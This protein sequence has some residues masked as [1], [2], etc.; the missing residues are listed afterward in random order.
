MEEQIHGHDSMCSMSVLENELKIMDSFIAK[1]KGEEQSFYKS[2]KE[3]IEF[4][5]DMLE[6]NIQNG[7]ITVD[8]YKANIM[9][10]ITMQ[11]SLLKQLTVKLGVKSTHSK[12]VMERINLMKKEIEE[13]D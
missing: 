1:S 2:K 11:E 13:F 5:K 6:N 4:A 12:R 8:K 9:K 10:Y 3:N 7:I